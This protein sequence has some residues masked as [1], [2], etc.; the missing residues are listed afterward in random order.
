MLNLDYCLF[1]IRLRSKSLVILTDAFAD[2]YKALFN[3]KVDPTTPQPYG[4]DMD[5][6]IKQIN[7]PVLWSFKTFELPF[8]W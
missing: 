6:F 7:L 2:Y 5:N 8:H 4:I 1:T 3:L